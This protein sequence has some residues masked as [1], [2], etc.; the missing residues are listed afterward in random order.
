MSGVIGTGT[1]LK[2]IVDKMD[3]PK[4]QAA[5]SHKNRNIRFTGD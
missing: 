1:N 2:T 3:I 4:N 5:V